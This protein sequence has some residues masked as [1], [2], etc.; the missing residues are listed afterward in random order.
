MAVTADKSAPRLAEQEYHQLVR[1]IHEL[2]RAT[3]PPG[4]KVAVVSK[5]DPALVSLEG[6]RGWHFPQNQR[7]DYAGHYPATSEDAISHL[8]EV[9]DRGAEYLVFPR[10]AF[11][12]LDHYRDF[13]AH[14]EERYETVLRQEHACRVFS[15]TQGAGPL[16]PQGAESHGALGQIKGLVESLLPPEA[17]LVV[18][19]DGGATLDLGELSVVSL[20]APDDP[21]GLPPAGD[22][23]A[24]TRLEERRREGAD[25]L[26]LLAGLTS[27]ED[28]VPGLMEHVRSRYP[29][30]TRQE[31]VCAIYDLGASGEEG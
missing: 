16:E 3:I 6:R 22:E 9:R 18:L 4:A 27:W 30:V 10:T 29:L 1:Q 2:V 19:D 26:V 17:T 20:D 21:P 23:A 14:L 24:I 7:G 31:H 25:F 11:W 8:E 13:A 28:R 15:L 12:W 5:G